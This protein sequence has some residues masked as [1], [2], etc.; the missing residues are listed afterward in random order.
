M[1]TQGYGALDV[2]RTYARARELCQQV[3]DTPQLF[4]V[5]RGLIVY[6]QNHGQIQAAHQLGEQL[7]RLAQAQPDPA[8]LMLAHYML[9]MILFFRG[10]PASAQTHLTQAL[11]L[12]TPQQHAGL[13]VR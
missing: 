5:L 7:L 1:S 10:E 12:Y 8:L 13:A 11:A 3:G 4:P 9:G 6:Y 2:Q